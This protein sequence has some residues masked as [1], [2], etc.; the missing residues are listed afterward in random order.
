[1][2]KGCAWCVETELDGWGEMLPY[3]NLVLLEVL[4]L[5]LASGAC[6]RWWWC[7][8]WQCPLGSVRLA[9]LFAACFHSRHVSVGNLS[10]GECRK[11][12]R[13]LVRY[14]VWPDNVKMCL[15]GALLVLEEACFRGEGSGAL[16]AW[17]G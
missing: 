11:A 10:C 3:V 12:P 1:M 2:V 14:N 13:A 9:T 7:L 6:V 16:V 4:R 15:V 5:V 8:Q 17:V